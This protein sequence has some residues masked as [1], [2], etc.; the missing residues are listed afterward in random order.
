MKYKKSLITFIIFIL[1]YIYFLFDVKYIE[2]ISTF[3]WV[4]VNLQDVVWYEKA[5]INFEEINIKDKNWNNINGL[6]MTWTS[7]KTVFY[8]HWN[9][10]PLNYFYDEL[11]YI[12]DLWYSVFAYDYPGYWKS[13]WFPYKE[14]VDEF[15]HIFFE[16]IK[17]EKN[18]D[19]KNLIV[20]WYSVWTAVAVDFASK[21]EFDKLIL[22]APFSSRY[23]MW[24]KYFF[25]FPPQKLFFRQNSYNT[26]DLVKSFKNPVLIFHWNKDL[27]VPFSQWKKVFE[28]YLWEKHFI[29]IDGAWHNYLINDFWYSLKNIISWFIDWRELAFDKLFL[30]EELKNTFEKLNEIADNNDMYSKIENQ[31]NKTLQIFKKGSFLKTLDLKW[32]NSIT[33]YV[34]NKV[35]FN[36]LKYIPNDLE[37]LT[38]EY[39]IDSKWNSKLRKIALEN[40]QKMSENFYKNFSTKIKVV[41]AYR[42]YDYQVGIIAWWCSLRFC[43]KPGF[44]EHQTWLAFDL[45]ETTTEKEFLEKSD[46][47][48]Y[49][50]WLNKNAYKYWFT[51]SYKNWIEIDGYENEPWHWRYVW[52][53]FATYLQENDL[54]FGKF[55]NGTK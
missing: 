5:N 20:W 4:W 8:F 32:D 15:S 13:T 2:T 17:S 23:D 12:N 50:D 41:S 40:L 31:E 16:H 1:I 11:K 18:I 38:W 39:L 10:W 34:S 26:F 54:S 6:Y 28:S 29:E 47:K 24:A 42:S 46:Y 33:K 49:F 55:M 51:N 36:D 22:F 7:D 27:I 53:D 14:N 43:S 9:G 19:N 25:S 48:K 37:T 44:S 45:F 3:P 21:N 30:D 35:S 52:V